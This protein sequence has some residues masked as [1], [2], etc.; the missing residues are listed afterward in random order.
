GNDGN[1]TMVEEM[2]FRNDVLVVDDLCKFLTLIARKA[3]FVSFNF[4]DSSLQRGICQDLPHMLL[5]HYNPYFKRDYP[6][7]L[8]RFKGNSGVKNRVPV[9]LDL[10]LKECHL[11]RSPLKIWSGP[12]VSVGSELPF[13]IQDAAPA[14]SAA[15]PYHITSPI[16]NSPFSP[17]LGPDSGATG[18]RVGQQQNLYYRKFRS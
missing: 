7:L 13:C 5:Y 6:H 3:S 10:D 2:F 4:I 8:R 12:A 17:R 9:A 15:S 18:D 11:S 16:P 14:A 1:S